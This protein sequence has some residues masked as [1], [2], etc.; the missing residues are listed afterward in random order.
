MKRRRRRSVL[1]LGIAF[2]GVLFLLS[3][4]VPRV[5]RAAFGQEITADAG[6][7][8]PVRDATTEQRI[9]SLHEEA[10]KQDYQARRPLVSR[11]VGLG[12]FLV[13]CLILIAFLDRKIKQREHLR[14]T[15]FFD[16]T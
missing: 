9:R 13:V 16:P 4:P 1:R 10:A 2:T 6:P 3:G 5:E 11:W 15:G 8:Q 14:K 7:A 12:I